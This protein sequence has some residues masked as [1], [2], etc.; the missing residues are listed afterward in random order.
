[1]SLLPDGSFHV[2]ICGIEGVVVEQDEDG[3]M[4]VTGTKLKAEGETPHEPHLLG[5]MSPERDDKCG[6]VAC[7]SQPEHSF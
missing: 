2:I 6:Y 7:N 1:M 5:H 4:R 3:E